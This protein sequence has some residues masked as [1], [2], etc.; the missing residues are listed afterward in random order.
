MERVLHDHSHLFLFTNPAVEKLDL[1][2]ITETRILPSSIVKNFNVLKAGFS[3]IDMRGEKLFAKFSVDALLQQFPLRLIEHLMPYSCSLF[4]NAWL[5]YW[6]PQSGWC[7]IPSAE[8]FTSLSPNLS[9]LIV[10][11]YKKRPSGLCIFIV[12]WADRKISLWG[13]PEI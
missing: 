1:W 5:A 13:S 8:C 11:R 10:K 4:W 6:L 2:L 12:F 3:H 7:K 9:L